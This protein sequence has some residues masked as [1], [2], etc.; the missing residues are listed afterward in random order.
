MR[1]INQPG[2]PGFTPTLRIPAIVTA[3]S[4]DR[5]RC[6]LKVGFLS[7]PVS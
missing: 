2:R 7:I 4:D 6:D 1:R 3:D 5:D